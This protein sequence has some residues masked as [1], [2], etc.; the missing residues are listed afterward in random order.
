MLETATITTITITALTLLSASSRR[1]WPIDQSEI[2][3]HE[4]VHPEFLYRV[5]TPLLKS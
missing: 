1:I 2:I 5:R 3:K 4:G